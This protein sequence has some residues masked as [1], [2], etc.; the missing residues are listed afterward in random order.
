MKVFLIILVV[1]AAALLAVTKMS[2]TCARHEE[3]E[4]PCE[5][6]LRWWECSGVDEACPFRKGKPDA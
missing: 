3:Q 5:A 4:D 1:A 6:C 2:G